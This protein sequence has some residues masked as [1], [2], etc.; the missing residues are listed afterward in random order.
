[1]SI[2]TPSPRPH[3]QPKSQEFEI[4]LPGRKLY[5][6]QS[7]EEMERLR[8]RLTATVKEP[9]E[10]VLRS[11]A[12]HKSA[13]IAAYHHHEQKQE[14]IKM[15]HREIYNEIENIRPHLGLLEAELHKLKDPAVRLDGNFSKFGYSPHL[16]CIEEGPGM[17]AQEISEEYDEN[18]DWEIEKWGEEL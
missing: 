3:L 9:F 8:R 10:V 12:E 11:S 4:S 13:L 6:A 14:E 2:R 5:V 1:M 7:Q 15:L 17:K 16:R 18:K